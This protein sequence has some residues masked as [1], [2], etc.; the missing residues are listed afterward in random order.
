MSTFRQASTDIRRGDRAI[1]IAAD[2]TPGQVGIRKRHVQV[3]VA[4][5]VRAAAAAEQ[6]MLMIGVTGS[7]RKDRV[8]VVAVMVMVVVAIPIVIGVLR[9]AVMMTTASGLVAA[10]RDACNRG[11]RV[12]RVLRH[13]VA[14][15][16]A[17]VA[18]RNAKG[19]A[20]PNGNQALREDQGPGHEVEEDR[21]HRQ[22][23]RVRLWT[24][25]ERPTG[26]VVRAPD[27]SQGPRGS[28][29]PPPKVV[30]GRIRRPAQSNAR[31]LL[32]V[33]PHRTRGSLRVRG[34]RKP[35]TSRLDRSSRI[36]S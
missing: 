8:M 7:I 16:M 28:G 15:V 24:G 31:G 13:E 18:E 33:L 27:R 12:A 4:I 30:I 25:D 10:R 11:R 22:D 26:K 19:L 2:G 21:M 3:A 17:A 32:G 23:A 14:D 5:G 36:V 9:I 20:R 29:G 35:P 1:R 6:A 34:L